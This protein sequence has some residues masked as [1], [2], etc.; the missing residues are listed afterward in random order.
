MRSTEKAAQ[1]LA[2]VVVGVEIPVVPV[3]HQALRRDVALALLIGGAGFVAEAQPFALEQRIRH[4]PE[5]LRIHPALTDLDDADAVIGKLASA[6]LLAQELADRLAQRL[7][8]AADQFRLLPRQQPLEDDE[9]PQFLGT[10]PQSGQ[11]VGRALVAVADVRRLIDREVLDRSPQHVTQEGD[12]AI[13][14]RP[15][16]AKLFHERA[17]RKRIARALEKTVQANDPL[18]ALHARSLAARALQPQRP[19]LRRLLSRR[20]GGPR[21]RDVRSPDRPRSART[22]PPPAAVHTLHRDTMRLGIERPQ[23]GPTLPKRYSEGSGA[24]RRRWAGRKD[25]AP[26]HA[27]RRNVAARADIRR[28]FGCHPRR[29]PRTLRPPDPRRKAPETS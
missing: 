24:P 14:R 15:R 16:A 4:H 18:E 19:S 5:D 20:S 10:Q 6:R 13:E 2:I 1:R 23:S 21:K 28:A 17:Q 11:L 26:N 25:P 12:V 29:R 8:R 22:L 9:R 27:H 3:M 7:E